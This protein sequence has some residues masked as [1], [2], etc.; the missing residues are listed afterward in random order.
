MTAPTSPR[1]LSWPPLLL[2]PSLGI[3]TMSGAR[4]R[5]SMKSRQAWTSELAS[6][7]AGPGML[8][9][10]TMSG[11]GP[12]WLTFSAD[13]LECRLEKFSQLRSRQTSDL[14]ALQSRLQSALQ[15]RPEG[16]PGHVTGSGPGPGDKHR[17][18]LLVFARIY[19]ETTRTGGSA[20]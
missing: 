13:R 10:D 15:S 12:A 9:S 4:S 5:Q 17:G 19:I 6:L 8:R 20:P 16:T 7:L 3:S 11:G 2:A 18:L 14:P 1:S